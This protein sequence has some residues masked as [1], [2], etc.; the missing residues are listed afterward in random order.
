MKMTD[1]YLESIEP[2]SKRQYV[3]VDTNLYLFVE[4]SG[5]KIWQVR[6]VDPASG[7]QK[8]HKL[9]IFNMSSE[10]HI[11]LRE[12][13]RLALNIQHGVDEGYQPKHV[14]MK[15][16]EVADEWLETYAKG[17]EPTTEKS[18]R[19]RYKLYVEESPFYHKDINEIKRVEIAQMLASLEK[20][21]Q[22]AKKVRY[23]Y[24]MLFDY[25]L[26]LGYIEGESPVPDMKHIFGKPAPVK[27]RAAVTNDP[28]KFGEIVAKIKLNYETG[29]NGAGLL[30]F[31]AYC[32]T[33]PREAR[34]L[35]WHHV[36]WKDS[37]I[38]LSA[39]DTKTK[40]PLII[41]LSEQVT[42]ILERQKQRRC[43]SILPND[44]IFF[45]TWRGPKYVLSDAVPTLKLT[46][47]GIPRREQ[48]AHG[49]R[50]CASTYLRDELHF[51]DNPI[52]L[53]LN[54]A[55]GTPSSRPY[56]QSTLLVKRKAMM[57]AWADWVDERSDEALARLS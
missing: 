14:N 52:E 41:P 33:R 36:I 37:V 46:Q 11:S 53:Q 10:E 22:T 39:K 57:Q 54:H 21:Q 8:Y 30:L 34:L 55:L 32:F 45:S 42:E 35:Q 27:N 26:D 28:K 50:S 4:S 15:F 18:T 16:S 48:S 56:N 38:K 31:L 5:A 3:L 6:Y 43:S 24:K 20:K 19:N 1:S 9:G 49:F 17:I 44:Y 2:T 12:A 29:D 47:L 7:K 13:Q 51:E 25:A 23:L 40:T